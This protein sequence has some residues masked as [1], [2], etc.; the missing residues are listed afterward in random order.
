MHTPTPSTLTL[1]LLCAYLL[2][3]RGL[4]FRRVHAVEAKFFS[5][6]ADLSTMSTAEANRIR[7]TV[8]QLE[9]PSLCVKVLEFGFFRTYGIPS[10]SRTL[11]LTGQ[12]VSPKTAPRR[13][14]NT[15]ALDQ[16]ISERSHRDQHQLQSVSRLNQIHG[17]Y[18]KKGLIL[19]DDMLYTL[20]LAMREPCSWIDRYEWRSL[21][22]LERCAMG[23]YHQHWGQM[24]HIDFSALPEIHGSEKQ[25]N[26]L[27]FF[28]DLC[29]RI[30]KYEEKYLV[31]A[32]SNHTLAVSTA[33]LLLHSFPLLLQLVLTRVMTAAMDDRLREAIIS[34]KAS[35]VY[36]LL[37]YTCMLARRVYVRH[38][39]LPR[40]FSATALVSPSGRG[41]A[42][43]FNSYGLVPIYVK[44]PWRNCLGAIA[45]YRAFSRASA[46]WR[47]SNVPW[48]L[49]GDSCWSEDVLRNDRI[50]QVCLE[51]MAAMGGEM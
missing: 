51:G 12:L 31:P 46:A 4:R 19:N 44:P 21:T 20:A 15:V 50:E 22:D 7:S 3:C 33:A 41:G 48:R 16:C 13:Y 14:A 45:L 35:L 9:F 39:A 26:G 40:F 28:G 5:K 49:R 11:A 18:I 43:H 34:D 6:R 2:I 42:L 17:H 29:T 8:A 1:P 25:R 30:D 24:M 47:C 32:A 27:Q 23:L 10:I 37:L 38:G 36:S